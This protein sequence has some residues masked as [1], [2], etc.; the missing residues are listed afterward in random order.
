M[1]NLY[2]LRDIFLNFY[3][4]CFELLLDNM[5]KEVINFKY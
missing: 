2:N 4:F 5:I 3:N 1:K